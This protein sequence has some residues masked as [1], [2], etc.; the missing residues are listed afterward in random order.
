[1]NAFTETSPTILCCL[2]SAEV[3]GPLLGSV[4]GPEPDG[5]MSPGPARV[6]PVTIGPLEVQILR[7][8]I[9]RFPVRR[10]LDPSSPRVRGEEKQTFWFR[11]AE[12]SNE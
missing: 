9:G 8:L 12:A 6:L 2:P 11:R 1:M 4:S 3:F 7:P 5:S 10:L